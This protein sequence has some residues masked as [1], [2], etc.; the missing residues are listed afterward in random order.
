MVDIRLIG[1][2]CLTLTDCV[3]AAIQTNLRLS[4]RSKQKRTGRQ[5]VRARADFSSQQLVT[6]I[7]H[8]DGRMI[9]EHDMFADALHVHAIPP[10]FCFRSNSRYYK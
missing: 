9:P 8:F 10:S 2:L 3:L 5:F 6:H 1:G 4:L 7:Q